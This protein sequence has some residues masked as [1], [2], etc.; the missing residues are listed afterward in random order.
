MSDANAQ[1][2]PPPRALKR[3]DRFVGNW[4]MT[5]RTLDSEVDNVTGRTTFEWLPGG[6]FLQQRITLDFAGSRSRPGGDRLR[7]TEQHVPVDGLSQHDGNSDPLSLG[8][9][10]RRVD[11]HDRGA[12]G[13]VPRKWSEDGEALSGGWRPDEGREGTGNV[14]YD[15]SG[16]RAS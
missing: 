3:L 12:R 14:A 15:I 4:N 1:P 11:D 13:D 10:G 16:T 9:R 6:F 7:P 2:Q 8:N 5:G